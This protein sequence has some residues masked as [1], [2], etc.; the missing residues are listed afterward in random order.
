MAHECPECGLR[1]HCGGD[2][3]DL[4][5]A[6]SKAEIACVHC[7]HNYEDDDEP[8]GCWRCDGFGIVPTNETD[9][10]TGIQWMPCPACSGP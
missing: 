6:G 10:V 3:D 2:I 9:C 8:Y 4:V 1:C 7:D 5:F